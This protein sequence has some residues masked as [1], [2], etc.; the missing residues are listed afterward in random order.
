MSANS[1]LLWMSAR[2]EG[3][4]QQ[5]RAA[6]EELHLPE[7]E[8]GS[9]TEEREG[10]GGRNELPLYHE[11]RFNLQRLGHAEFFSGAGEMDWRV[12][13]PCLAISQQPQG[14]LGVVTGAR[15][16]NLFGR[17]SSAAGKI[18]EVAKTDACPD[19]L[20]IHAKNPGDLE[21]IG[22]ETGLAVQRDAPAMILMNLPP[23]DEPAV[24]RP[25]ELPIGSDWRIEQFSVPDL[26]W[27]P[28][29]RADAEE[30][31]WGV[32]R[33]SWRYRW[34]VFLCTNGSVFAVPGQVGKYLAL[35]HT[36]R[37][38]ILRYDPGVLRLTVPLSCRPPFLV[39]RALI[40][41]SG[42]LPSLEA[43]AK[44]KALLHYTNVPGD[45]AGLVAALLRQG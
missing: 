39:E 44:G 19:F 1:L 7:T 10:R 12:T 43:G 37:K 40:L 45:I 31:R 25:D 41:C 5:F 20:R 32:F 28:A 14:S 36:R 4:W 2:R 30:A 22:R 15:S 21:L 3:T 13:P 18:L 29:V 8:I 11:L 6:V 9:E 17:L 26:G 24:R 16:R 23:V 42:S 27:R 35:R 33:F 38:K 34:H